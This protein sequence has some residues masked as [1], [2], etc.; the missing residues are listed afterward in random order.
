[1][2][3]DI[4]AG[5]GTEVGPTRIAKRTREQVSWDNARLPFHRSPAWLLLRA[6]M[7]LVLDRQTA[8]ADV[9]SQY[10]SLM[11]YH[12]AQVLQVATRAADIPS[13]TLFSMRAKLARRIKK[14]DPTEGYAMADGNARYHQ[15]FRSNHSEA[16]G[17][18]AVPGHQDT[19][20]AKAL[21]GFIPPRY[22]AE[23]EKSQPVFVFDAVSLCR[24]S[25]SQGTRRSHPL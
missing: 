7:R 14:L 17:E 23:A 15:L 16:L 19:S 25:R 18:C 20:H 1:M 13:D 11:A 24:Q 5:L 6:A 22:R 2:L 8:L 21:R 9:K 12:H 10:K 3:V 4:I